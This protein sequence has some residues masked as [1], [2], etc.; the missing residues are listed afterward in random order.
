MFRKFF[1]LLVVGLWGVT[2]LS[3]L[4]RASAVTPLTRA[5]I[6]Y[7]SNLVQ[8]MPQN[9]PK[10]QARK[11]DRMIPGDGL[12]TGRASLADLRFNDGSLARVGEQA[13][14]RFV[15]KSRNF[16]LSNGTVL[17]LIP[18]GR[19]P[20]RIQTPNAAAAIR[21][22]AL[23]VRYDQQSDTTVVGSL[24][25]SGIEVSNEDA[26]QSQVLQ[27]GQ[28]IVVVKDRIQGLY[29]FDLRTFYET[30]EL[31]RGL[32]LIQRNG[33][34]NIDPAI[35]S[36]QAETTAAVAAQKP[37]TGEG[38][39]QNP[40]FV[41][42]T[43]TPDST[44]FTNNDIVQDN[45][46]AG[47]TGNNSPTETLLQT[48]EVLP[49]SDRQPINTTNPINKPDIQNNINNNNNNNNNNASGNNQPGNQPTSS[50]DR[51]SEPTPLT[52]SSLPTGTDKPPE[53]KP[54]LPPTD[55][56]KPPETKPTLPPTD[57]SKPPETKPT[58]PPTDTS[59]PPEIKPTLPPT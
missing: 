34:P 3:D 23:F 12:S 55:T 1:P 45:Y 18:P 41:Q 59:K 28:M 17:L 35:A 29:D 9:Q 40:S 26:S 16:R 14:F 21:G 2:T 31:V 44:E 15:P 38:V 53:T 24:T 39:I 27:A 13:I 58:L 7:L 11:L 48:G 5:E 47:I 43:N 42:L 10:R 52:P 54:T 4:N 56:S 49:I 37:V 6:Q 46:P 36:V 50:T 33:I 22:S 20:T 32:D 57:T 19:G 51:P 30:S 8:L 25:N